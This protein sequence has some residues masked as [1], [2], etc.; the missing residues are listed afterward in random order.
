MKVDEG[1]MQAA[2]VKLHRE[3]IASPGIGTALGFCSGKK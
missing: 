1:W 2:S 3:R